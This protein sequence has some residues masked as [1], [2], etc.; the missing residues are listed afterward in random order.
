VPSPVVTSHWSV[1]RILVRRD[2]RKSGTIEA[3]HE[4]PDGTETD[5][6]PVSERAAVA[7]PTE[8]LAQHIGT[9]ALQPSYLLEVRQHDG[10]LI[11]VASG[12]PPVQLV[13]EAADKF[14][15]REISAQITFNRGVTGRIVGLTFVQGGSR[16]EGNK[17]R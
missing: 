9:F 12:N 5:D 16:T 3:G 8:V 2:S 13:A 11:A 10:L 6:T 17:V 4:P 15:I 1:P 7:L 14:T